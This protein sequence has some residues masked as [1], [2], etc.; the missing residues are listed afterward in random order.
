MLLLNDVL[1]ISSVFIEPQRGE[2][3]EGLG[4][5]QI[6]RSELADPLWSVEITTPVTEF[7]TG[8]RIRAILNDINRPNSYFRVTDPVSATAQN[9]P[10]GSLLTSVTVASITGGLVTFAGQPSGYVF[11]P[12]D[13]FHIITGGRHYYFEIAQSGT[14]G[15]RT[16]PT[17]PSSIPNGAACVFVS[18]QIRVQMVP[19]DLRIGTAD[20][21]NWKMS[22]FQIKAIQKI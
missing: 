20:S 19:T 13:A 18:P 6:I 5:G 7:N 17:M 11:Q 22:A 8:R 1:N 16:T 3:V 12:G 9:D 4:S 2:E 15:L 10:N 14:A 21:S